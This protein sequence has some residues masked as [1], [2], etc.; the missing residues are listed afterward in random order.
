MFKTALVAAALLSALTLTPVFAEE[1]K[2]PRSISISG[3]GEV[4]VV[5]DIAYV[6]IGVTTQAT[7]ARE[8][9]DANTKSMKSL[10][11]ALKSA[12]VEARDMATSNFSVGPRVDYGRDNSQP[13]KVVGYDVNNMV[14]VTVRKIDDLGGILDVAVTSGSNTINSI[15]FSIAKPEPML[16]EARKAAVADAKHKAEIYATAGGFTV[17]NIVSLSEGAAYAPPPQ[18]YAKSGRAESAADVPIAQGERAL[19]VDVSITYEIK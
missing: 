17:G 18:Y 9:L 13:G 11:D 3:H 15:S 19:S 2:L 7:T 12:G 6:S 8:A 4:Q 16:D 10:L 1:A 14:T 5:P